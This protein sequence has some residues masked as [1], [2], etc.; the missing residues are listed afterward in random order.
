[1][2]KEHPEYFLKEKIV[3]FEY[4]EIKI[5]GEKSTNVLK[6][7]DKWLIQ[8]IYEGLTHISEKVRD[9]MTK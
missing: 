3:L 9:L 8:C 5:S 1:M 6:T 7:Q 4:T 2:R